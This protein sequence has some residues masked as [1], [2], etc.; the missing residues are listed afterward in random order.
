MINLTLVIYRQLGSTVSLP[1][2]WKH[3]LKQGRPIFYTDV[4]NTII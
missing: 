4:I 2:W 1:V 3:S